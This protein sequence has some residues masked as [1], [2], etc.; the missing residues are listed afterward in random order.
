LFYVAHPAN[1]GFCFTLIFPDF[2]FGSQ[3]L[4]SSPGI[5]E[6]ITALIGFSKSPGA[7]S[8]DSQGEA[9]QL[10]QPEPS[11]P[12]LQQAAGYTAAPLFPGYMFVR[13]V[14]DPALLSTVE[15]LPGLVRFVTSGRELVAVTDAEITGILGGCLE[16]IEGVLTSQTNRKDIVISV[17]SIQ[18]S[19][20]VSPGNYQIERLS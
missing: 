8:C 3:L 14:A 16:G 7:T 18:R 9:M 1:F 2:F 17:S 20:K 10:V 4:T 5:E 13:M 6:R 15:R 19:L 11:A 12:G